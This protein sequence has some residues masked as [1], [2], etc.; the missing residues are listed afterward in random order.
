MILLMAFAFVAGAGTAITPCVLPVL[1]AILSASALGGR[2]RPLGIVLGLAITFT[3]TIVALARL[4]SGVGV[5]ASTARTVAIVVLILAG[6]VM[7]VPAVSARLEA[8]L[9]RLARFG[10]RTR[11]SGFWSG[12]GVGAALG[13][14]CAPCAGPILAAVISVS[15]STGGPT[16]R[17]V[18][19]AIAFAVGLSAVLLVYGFAGRAVL[20]RLRRRLRGHVVERVL[21]GVLLATG[22]A[23]AFNL[24]VQFE[25]LLARNAGSL[26]AIF[27]DPTKGLEGSHAVQRRLASLRPASQFAARQAAASATGSGS[28]PGSASGGSSSENVGWAISGVKT[29]AIADLGAAPDF[30]QTEDWFNT[31]GDRPLSLRS[32]RGKV[33]I[34]DFWTY[35]CI[36]C[37]RTLPYLKGLYATY[38]RD[39]LEIVGVETPEFTFEQDPSNVGDAIHSDGIRYPVVQDNRYGTWNAYDNQYWPADYFINAHGNVVHTQFGEGDYTQDEALVRELLYDAG[40]HHLPAPMTATAMMPSRGLD[41]PETYLNP[42]RA[43]L[44]QKLQL[45]TA[46]YVYD[47]GLTLN[48][49]A[50]NGTWTATKQSITPAGSGA[51]IRG[52]FQAQHV[53]L[54]LTSAG[55]RPRRVTLLLNGR[56]L[57]RGVEGADVHGSTVVVRGQRLYSLLSLPTD[58]MGTLTVKVPPGV[59][60][61]DFTFG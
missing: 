35:T 45:G 8:P 17:V 42:E 22:V 36:N 29:P 27:T 26:P 52:A 15:A 46:D 21:G 20:D 41:T 49:F 1:P 33:V 56:P 18:V 44:L 43:S 14:V 19:V 34:V 10:P 16:A 28:G 3:V 55:A 30:R 5:G 58:E 61:Y 51:T 13:F 54:V 57:T 25:N 60:A 24:D 59:S 38:H 50:L 53:Y 39:G 32:L 6:A 40:H 7:L 9:S 47:K 2:R 11:G 23:M 4:V 12:M 31:P 37:I 48:Q